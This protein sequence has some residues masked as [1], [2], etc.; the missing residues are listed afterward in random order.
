MMEIADVE[1]LRIRCELDPGWRRPAQPL[2]A[3]GIY[4]E[5]QTAQSNDLTQ[6]ATKPRFGS[7]L[8]R[9]EKSQESTGDKSQ[10]GQTRPLQDSERKRRLEEPPVLRAKGG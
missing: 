6:F 9:R 8:R 2:D 3:K 1:L 10:I 4:R 5:S 7:Q